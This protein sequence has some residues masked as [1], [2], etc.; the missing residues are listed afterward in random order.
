MARLNR[1]LGNQVR[2][3]QSEVA[4]ADGE[5]RQLIED[6]LQLEQQLDQLRQECRASNER[7]HEADRKARAALDQLQ[8]ELSDV[9]SQKSQL[10]ASLEVRCVNIYCHM[11]FTNLII[12][13]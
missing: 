5:R 13:W 3:L 1:Q 7:Q 9:L 4:H 10:H 11:F 6:R 8:A 12:F 2:S